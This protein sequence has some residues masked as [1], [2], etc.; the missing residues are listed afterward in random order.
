MRERRKLLEAQPLPTVARQ[1]LA[2]LERDASLKELAML[3]EP[4]WV[5]AIQ[6]REERGE[7][8]PDIVEDLAN[9]D[10]DEK[11]RQEAV[12]TSNSLNC[13]VQLLSLSP[14]T[15]PSSHS[16]A[17]TKVKSEE[18]NILAVGPSPVL[19]WIRDR[20]DGPELDLF[21]VP[22]T[23]TR[24]LSGVE[25]MV[26]STKS[27]VSGETS[28]GRS[29]TVPSS[30]TNGYSTPKGLLQLDESMPVTR[31]VCDTPPGGAATRLAS[32]RTFGGRI[33]GSGDSFRG[34]ETIE[35]GGANNRSEKQ[36][37]WAVPVVVATPAGLPKVSPA[38]RKPRPFRW[39]V[40]C[41]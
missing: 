28:T 13:R 22:C 27:I 30:R 25:S 7:A 3:Q 5:E 9:Q 17:E 40:L 12:I 2:K 26:S 39:L 33:G 1:I 34:L 41:C 29:T 19:S 23:V 24:G 14:T 21:T 15:P 37:R 20:P 38:P 8:L 11:V 10:T 4:K 16:L 32:F 6:A 18:R 31:S 36:I 35:R